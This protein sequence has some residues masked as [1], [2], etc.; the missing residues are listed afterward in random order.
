MLTDHIANAYQALRRNRAR[1][2]LTVLGIA[3]GI[4][5]ITCILVISG[6]VQQMI[7]KQVGDIDGHLAVIRPGQQTSAYLEK[8]VLNL[9]FFG[10]IYI[11]IVCLI[12]EFLTSAVNVPFYLGGTS[13][14]IM[15]VVTMDFRTQ[16]AS[17]VMSSQYESLMKRS[18]GRS[19]GKR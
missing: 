15:V 17:Y 16:I 4:A 3:I 6:G 1:T 2:L 7:G 13:L 12:P 18:Q 14:L 10:A 5:S 9:T 8:V 19:G 11:A